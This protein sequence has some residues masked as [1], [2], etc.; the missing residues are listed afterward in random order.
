MIAPRPAR[1]GRQRLDLCAGRADVGL[2][3]QVSAGKPADNT[4]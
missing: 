2:D 1:S 4:S 3:M